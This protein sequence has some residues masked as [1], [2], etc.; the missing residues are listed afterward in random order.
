[1]PSISTC[2]KCA[3]PVTVP[4]G[5]AESAA[6]RCPVCDAEY[7]AGKVTELTIDTGDETYGRTQVVRF[8]WNGGDASLGSPIVALQA[9]EAG[10]GFVD[11]PSPAGWPGHGYD[12]TRYHMI[13]HYRPDPPPDGTIADQRRHE[14][15]VDWEIPADFPAGTYRMVAVGTYWLGGSEQAYEV[16]STPFAVVQ[17]ADA[18]LAVTTDEAG[19][20]LRLTLPSVPFVRAPGESWPASGWRLQ[21][22][23][24]SPSQPIVVQ[25]PLQLVIGVDEVLLPG[26]Y[27]A[28]WD[29]AADAHRFDPVAAELTIPDGAAVTVDAHIDADRSPSPVEAPVP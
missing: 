8:A 20:I 1:M 21:D 12:N 28:H 24:R 26:I 11:L 5:L 15:L 9:E 10:G 27:L 29:A 19:W 13:T 6:V 22:P 7:P 4:D 16:A 17:A 23:L 14:W 25:A 18:Q 2:P 3:Q